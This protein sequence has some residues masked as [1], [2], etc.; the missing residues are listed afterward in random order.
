M[1]FRDVRGVHDDAQHLLESMMLVSQP[2]G[3][4][5]SRLGD[6]HKSKSGC[7]QY[8]TSS[9]QL[10]D[11]VVQLAL[12]AGWSGNDTIR[13]EEGHQV[14]FEKEQ[15]YITST[16]DSHVVTIVRKKN[17]PQANHG[18]VHEQ[19]GQKEGWVNYQGKVYCCTVPHG[20]IYVRRNGI[21]VFCETCGTIPIANHINKQYICPSCGDKASFGTCTIPHSYKLLTQLLAGAG[22]KLS[23]GMKKKE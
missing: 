14:W 4:H 12:H 13:Y 2:R 9:K 8:Y 20:V 6:G 19:N 3:S 1:Q 5:R 15:R 10:A 16:T 23:L 18:H 11:D 7:Y 22:L 17:Q 21:P